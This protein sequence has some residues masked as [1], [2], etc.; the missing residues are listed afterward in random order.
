MQC[1][2][3]IRRGWGAGGEGGRVR[4]AIT[5]V[6]LNATVSGTSTLINIIEE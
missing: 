6:R 4:G 2:M 3:E 5:G 1:A